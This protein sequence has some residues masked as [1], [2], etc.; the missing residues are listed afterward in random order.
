M[1]IHRTHRDRVIVA[2]IVCGL[3]APATASRAASFDCGV[4]RQPVEILICADGQVSELDESLGNEYAALLAL[5]PAGQRG[6]L[7]T[8]Q[9]EWIERRNS[10]C[11]ID[12]ATVVSDSNR[13]RLTK[14]LKIATL[15]RSLYLSTLVSMAKDEAE[16]EPDPP[17]GPTSSGSGVLISSTG[18]VI[19]N[20][21]VIDGCGEID[22]GNRRLGRSPA[23]VV[24]V[25]LWADLALLRSEL[26]P[27]A[28]ATLREQPILLG[29]EVIV[30]GYPLP[31]VLGSGVIVTQ[32]IVS[33][34]S[35]LGDDSSKMQ[36]SA[37]I[38]P[39]SSGGPVFDSR[40]NVVGVVVSTL[41]SLLD[42]QYSGPVPQNVN[43]AVK[44]TAV[45]QFLETH[46]T[47]RTRVPSNTSG[48]VAAVT[49][50]VSNSVVRITCR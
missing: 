6:S 36:I 28:G 9:R 39:G 50:A 37:P 31:G 3:F 7:R 18:M 13:A 30:L 15:E 12:E 26:S 24:A 49:S 43:F 42:A 25:D 29:E 46:Q 21:H 16:A 2:A 40:G 38:Q 23:T 32:G 45:T 47:D 22:V 1:P 27:D 17:S 14:C 48:G 19:T 34:A 41:S 11:H 5:L 10:G 20:A 35:G 8:N 33:A 44:A 4:A